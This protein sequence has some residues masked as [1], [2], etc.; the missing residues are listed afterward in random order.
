MA[1][2]I[3][4]TPRNQLLGLLADALQGGS[5]FASKP[6]GYDNPPVRG[7][8]DLFGLPAITNTLNELSYGGAL[9]TGS[10]MTYRPKA[11]T[12]DAAMAAAP[13][14]GG[15]PRAINAGAAAIG[16]RLEPGVTALVNRTMAQGGQPAQLLQD[17]AQGTQSNIY[18]PHTPLKP[19]PLVGTRYQTTDLGGIAPR[20]QMNWDDWEGASIMTYP[21]DMLSRNRRIDNVSNIQIANPATSVGGLMFAADL[22]NI[23]KKIGY[24][25]NPSAATSQNN[26][27]MQA[28]EENLRLG[29][30]GKVLMAP[31]TMPKGGENF[32]TTPTEVALSIIDTVN[33][34]TAVLDALSDRV[35][36]AT[37]K[38]VKGKYKD[39]VGFNDS[40]L[41]NQLFKGEGLLA[42]S[43]GDL[44]KVVIDKLSSA[45]AQKNFGFNYPDLQNSILDPNVMNKSPFLMGDTIFQALP[46][47]GTSRGLHPA[48]SANMPGVFVGNTSGAPINQFMGDF[49][50]RKRLG[51]VGKPGPRPG[52]FAD[53]DQLTRG[54]LS[55]AGE[56]ISMFLDRA[57]I[58]RLKGLLSP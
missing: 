50:A 20:T 23:A 5:N 12:L 22:K 2:E 42:G 18:L 38:G 56:D 19:N 43:A 39:F 10:G 7:L 55:T 58:N 49:Y 26:R 29:G 47:L 6:F 51:Q 57:Q 21:T 9:G 37:V 52:E 40:G 4:A 16:Q 11:E 31:H 13:L 28:I 41:R 8:L 30:S 46:Y 24:A 1:D 48:Y 35:R 27:A 14:L 54:Q 15:A 34:S 36:D 17:L 45:E 53:A 25:S 32:S 44:R 3:R 33:P